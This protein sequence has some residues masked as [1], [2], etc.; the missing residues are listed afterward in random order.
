[1]FNVRPAESHHHLERSRL[2]NSLP[3]TEGFVVWLEAPY[4]YGKSV[5]ASQWAWQ[6]EDRGWRVVW[7][8]LAGRE[9]KS[10]IA[11]SLELPASAP[12][13]AVVD[14]LWNQP[15]LLVLEELEGHED[16]QPLLK[17]VG[18]L[19][20]LASRQH[21]PYPPLPQLATAG[22]LIHVTAE[23]LAFTQDEARQLFSNPDQATRVWESTNGWPLPLHFASLS[24][25]FP[26]NAT[27]LEGVRRSVSNEAWRELLFVA[28]LEQL[29]ADAATAATEEL[30]RAGFLQQLDG[31]FRLHP[32]VAEGA[33][34]RYRTDVQTI[35]AACA[36]RLAPA[37][38]G[39]A[40]ENSGHLTGL[41]DLLEETGL[42]LPHSTPVNYLRWH[43]MAP[44]GN[45]PRRTAY[46]TI[47]KLLLNRY[48]EALPDAERLMVSEQ[49]SRS[50]QAT[51]ASIAVF[52]LASAKRFE[53]CTWFADRLKKVMPEDDPHIMGGA[54]QNL[55]YRAYMQA[56]YDEAEA[57]FRQALATYSRLEPTPERTILE[58][59]TRYGLYL[60]NW[61]I[62]GNIDEPLAGLMDMIHAG[63]LDEHG[64]VITRQ[65][66][67]VYLSKLWRIDEAIKLCRE[68]LA[69][70]APYHRLMIEAMLA[71]LHLDATKF[72]ALLSAARRW[73][74]N[75][76]SE[77]VS[78]LWLRTLRFTN[79]LD[80]AQRIAHTLQPGPYV[81]LELAWVAEATGDH[82]RAVALI[83]ETRGSYPYR[84]FG[85][86]WHAAD[87]AI[88]GNE[89]ALNELLSLVTA[90][91][92]AGGVLR[93]V[94]I[95]LNDVP[96][97]RPEL[98]LSY[99]LDAVLESGWQEAIE[100][101]LDEIPALKLRLHGEFRA[102]VMGR[103]V[104]LSDRQQQ[105]LALLAVGHSREHIGNAMWPEI[106]DARQRNNL[107][108]QL[109][110]L[111]KALEPWG[112][113]TYIRREGLTNYVSD[114]QALEKALAEADATTVARVF[115][116]PLFA[117]LDLQ[118]FTDAAQVLRERAI[119]LMFESALAAQDDAS[120]ELLRR[121]IEIDP[122]NEEAVQALLQ[123]L[124]ARG[125]E[126]EAARTYQRFAARLEKETGLKPQ[127][128]T[129]S[130]AA[131]R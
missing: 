118:E 60:I 129:T 38:R 121:L 128:L 70:A 1:M 72:P 24:D 83:Q 104:H 84:E 125:R 29:P 79:D 82:E 27:L 66:A 120:I 91:S 114:H 6:L 32:M 9:A 43:D 56:N 98:T 106:D 34:E 94:G 42:K 31:S 115:K 16:L 97:H 45:T 28:A 65:N 14:E 39:A 92:G 37:L 75:E 36:H 93:Y 77:R 21:L 107:G 69:R 81:N 44:Y 80:A 123:M 41:A 4:G 49:L 86:H 53:K 64:Y 8:S 57:L 23:Q 55:G 63:Q 58:T 61:E 131:F 113:A 130:I 100:L 26:T 50:E 95:G 62:H 51:L 76:L 116:E 103:E 3:D 10:A 18:G 19:V 78:A 117:G 108:V 30:V 5:L 90:S 127:D 124:V 73:E 40:F 87:Y 119:S 33:L 20:A 110:V 99:P 2:L 105:L 74:Q 89:E 13:G 112:V 67:A 102:E 109:N 71:F 122:L 85:M 12:W 15:T 7:L 54:Q 48:D 126:S 101:R 52:T 88:N 22:R 11:Q 68:A 59:K 25:S 35:V 47:A 17:S 46:A 96:R 111:R